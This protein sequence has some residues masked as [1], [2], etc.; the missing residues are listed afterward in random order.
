MKVV[1]FSE[2]A[3]VPASHEDPKNPG[4]VKRVLVKRDGFI[5]GRVQMINWATL[6]PGKSFALHYHEDM[7]EVFV[8]MKGRAVA[9]INGEEINVEKGDALVIDP[10]D[11]HE[12]YNPGSDPVLYLV[13]GIAGNKDGKSI[14]V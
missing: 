12:M 4:V 10:G 11:R 6:L 3:E 8:M 1:R 9:K 2:I 13:I 7:Q 14:N 5:D